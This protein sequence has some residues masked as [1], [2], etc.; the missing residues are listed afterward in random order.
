MNM[1]QNNIPTGERY[2]PPGIRPEQIDSTGKTEHRCRVLIWLKSGVQVKDRA[3]LNKTIIHAHGVSECCFL[4][5]KPAIMMI[6]FDRAEVKV[7]A[8]LKLIQAQGG[9]ARIVG[10]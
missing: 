1:L 5:D 4:R 10:C 8:L 6:T 7:A 9:H 3:A 2:H